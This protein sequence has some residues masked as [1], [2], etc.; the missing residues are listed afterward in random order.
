MKSKRYNY[1]CATCEGPVEKTP[2]GEGTG[3]HG[4]S[5]TTCGRGVKVKRRING[6]QEESN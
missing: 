4:W 5:C 1:E 3:L 2:C 6:K